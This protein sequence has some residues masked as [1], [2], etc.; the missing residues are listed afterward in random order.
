MARTNRHYVVLWCD[1]VA[2]DTYAAAIA[3][4]DPAQP[5]RTVG[6][7]HVGRPMTTDPA[8]PRDVADAELTARYDRVD[9]QRL[10]GFLQRAGR[11]VPTYLAGPAEVH[12]VPR[13]QHIDTA[14]LV[15]PGDEQQPV[16]D[17]DALL[18]QLRQLDGTIDVIGAGPLTGL[19]RVLDDDTVRDKLGTLVFQGGLQD[20]TDSKIKDPDTGEVHSGAGEIRT[21]PFA[22]AAFNNA[23]APQAA[24]E[25]LT[26][27]PGPRIL[28]PTDITRH[29]AMEFSSADEL[30]RL[31]FYGEVAGT[32]RNVYALYTEYEQRARAGL[33]AAEQANFR[34]RPATP[35]LHDAH[36][37]TILAEW[38]RA[39]EADRP[40]GAGE[41]WYGD[42][43][44]DPA[45]LADVPGPS[46][47]SEQRR[48]WGNRPVLDENPGRDTGTYVVRYHAGSQDRP[49]QTL[50]RETL[51]TTLSQ[52][53]VDEVR[54]IHPDPPGHQPRDLGERPVIG[55]RTTGRSGG[56]GR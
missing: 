13:G 37:P 8:A 6:M 47:T 19:E 46:A 34:S 45:G 35:V 51:L 17:L 44:L 54:A 39:Q 11:A 26:R 42:Y 20:W 30:E 53:R 41:A 27:W 33:S 10:A 28:L 14:E 4:T 15:V 7:V 18:E 22:K 55:A 50:H 49:A 24:Y 2:V 5:F 48:E 43:A 29:P 16:Q 23:A 36:L 1:N 52:H 21:Q 31:G 40:N 12:V 25:C 38:I 56:R 9:G 3:A 32:Y